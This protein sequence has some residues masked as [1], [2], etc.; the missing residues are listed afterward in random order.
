MESETLTVTPELHITPL[1]IATGEPELKVTA[2]P[3]GAVPKYQLLNS[4]CEYEVRQWIENV[5]KKIIFLITPYLDLLYNL[6]H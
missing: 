1:G 2:A 6:I 5:R 3:F 4:P